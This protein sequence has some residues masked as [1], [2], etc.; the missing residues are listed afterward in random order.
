MHN[1]MVARIVVGLAPLVVSAGS[2]ATGCYS[3]VAGYNT[4]CDHWIDVTHPEDCQDVFIGDSNPCPLATTTITGRRDIVA[5]NADC[6][7]QIKEL[8]DEQVCETIWTGAA[9]QG[10]SN[11]VGSFCP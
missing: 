6:V 2:W 9:T 3:L 4:A 11:A 1:R 5:W 10:C 7:V 8:N